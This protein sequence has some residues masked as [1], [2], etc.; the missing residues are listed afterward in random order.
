MAE[1]NLKQI[2][3]RLN[4]EFL[5]GSEDNRK[6]V[7]WY[8]DKAE[9]AEDVDSLRLSSAKILHLTELNQFKTKL[10]LEQEDRTTNYL[11]YAPFSKPD[12]HENHLE[13]VLL[14]CCTQNAF[15]PIVL[16]F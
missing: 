8:D 14:Y 7:F 10:F 6:L 3:D 13:D 16:R 4:A 5:S 1:L 15:L 12:V 9:F 11:I 2:E